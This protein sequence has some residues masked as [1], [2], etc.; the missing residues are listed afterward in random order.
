MKRF[1]KGTL[2]TVVDDNDHRIS[3]Y[4]ANGWKEAPI[5]KK[6][7]D[8]ADSQLEKAMLDIENSEEMADKK[9]GVKKPAKKVNDTITANT[10]AAAESEAVD[11]GLLKKEGE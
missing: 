1:I 7:Q 9:K 10:A 11:D 8:A 5:V 4:L 2:E 3:E 6:P